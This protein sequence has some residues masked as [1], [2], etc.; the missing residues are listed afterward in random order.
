MK[1]AAL[2]A[3]PN[4][5]TSGHI[6]MLSSL[7]VNAGNYLYNLILGRVLGPSA[8]SDAALMIT[9]LLIMSFLAMTFQLATAKFTVTFDQSVS[10][11]FRKKM[12]CYALLAGVIFGSLL[13][14]FSKDLQQIFQT[15]AYSMF[16]IL[17]IGVPIYFLLSV[18]RGVFQGKQRFGALS[19]T[20]QTEMWSRLLITLGLLWLFKTDTS[21][22]VSIGILCSLLL[23][24]FPLDKQ[25]LSINKPSDKLDSH[26][27]KAMIVFLSITAFYEMTQIIINNSDILLVKHYF[28][29]LEAGLYASL[30]LIGRVVYFVAWMFVM[31]LLPAVVQKQKNGESHKGELFKY[32]GWIALLSVAIVLS[33]AIMPELIINIMFGDLYISM[34][35]LLWLY[36]T[37]TS[38]FAISNIFCYYFLSLE[39]YIPVVISGVMG[40]VQVFL[41]VIFH[42]SLDQVVYVQ[43][44]AMAVLLISQCIFFKMY[45]QNKKQFSL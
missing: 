24:I 22:L 6:F 37:A 9:L 41:I 10:V 16:T 1:L 35:H 36:A 7:L 27:K 12:F 39:K 42:E 5:F 13:I 23:G 17:G 31:Q 11:H 44:I 21:I 20:Y 38:L 29:Q 32:V 8:F 28:S 3:L 45:S 15:S 19:M 18:N 33:C 40:L 26:Q 2:K 34:A 25:T 43:I 14:I 30:A 4:K